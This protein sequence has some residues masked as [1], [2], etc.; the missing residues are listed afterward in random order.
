MKNNK[1]YIEWLACTAAG[2]LIIMAA[3]VLKCQDNKINRLED[4][5]YLKK[6]NEQRATDFYESTIN[7]KTIQS[8]FNT[9]Q[10]YAIMKDCAVSMNHTYHYTSDSVLG[11]KKQINTERMKSHVCKKT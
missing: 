11:L 6:Q 9:L 3:L 1:H 4:E 5:L 10:E 2:L 8:K 7:I